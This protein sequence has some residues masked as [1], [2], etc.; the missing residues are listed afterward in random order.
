[1]SV[2]G[3][4]IDKLTRALEHEGLRL[5]VREAFTEMLVQVKGDAFRFKMLTAK[6]Y[7]WV[8]RELE[9]LEPSYENL[10]SSGKVPRGAEVPTPKALQFLPKR[11]PGAK[12]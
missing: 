1:M 5:E 9:H 2:R 6:Q 4:Q 10:F 8:I 7:A 3:E 12:P 11:P